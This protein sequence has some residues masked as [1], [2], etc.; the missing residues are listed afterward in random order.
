MENPQYIPK[1]V[2][3][4]VEAYRLASTANTSDWVI[5]D[6]NATHLYIPSADEDMDED[7]CDDILPGHMPYRHNVLSGQRHELLNHR[8]ALF[9]RRIGADMSGYINGGECMTEDPTDVNTSLPQSIVINNGKYYALYIPFI[10]LIPC[11]TY[12]NHEHYMIDIKQ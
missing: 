2:W 3:P 9:E 5:L 8:N 12:A 6:F 7:G 10:D 11:Q 1:F 4:T